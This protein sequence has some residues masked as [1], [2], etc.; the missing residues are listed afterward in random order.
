MASP[1]AEAEES[2][3]SQEEKK[4]FAKAEIVD[5]SQM[6][7]GKADWNDSS[8]RRRKFSGANADKLDWEEGDPVEEAGFPWM[9]VGVVSLLAVAAIGVG[10]YFVKTSPAKARVVSAAGPTLL[11]QAQE[12][13]AMGSEATPRA[14]EDDTARELV[15]EFDKFDL[16]A[17]EEAVK[18]FLNAATIT[19][20]AKW[21]RDKERVKPLMENY[22]GSEDIEPERLRNFDKS[23][24]TY[25]G[26]LLSSYVQ[27]NDFSSKPIAILKVKD[28][29]F[30]DWESWV[31]YCE[32]P[33]NKMILL[34]PKGEV[35]MRAY[36]TS[37]KYYNY[38]FS[39]DR[40][41]YSVKLFFQDQDRSLWAY[42][43]K[44]S[45]LTERLIRTLSSRSEIPMVVSVR[46]PEGGRADD[47]VILTRV[48]TDGWI[49]PAPSKSDDE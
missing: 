28:E 13:I 30:V 33:A 2:D 42:A 41:W 6:E 46:Y 3:L 21:I 35:L 22:Y 37:Q 27:L 17:T 20:K 11:Q 43:E 9:V 18:G 25:R 44:N 40:K 7:E 31:G 26:N 32:V 34:K 16:E 5:P 39:D 36:V 4:E 49:Y 14:P 19:E 10:V 47:Q 1:A 12:E 15:E 24:V 48:Y 29:Y 23:Q 38:G 45:Q 8:R